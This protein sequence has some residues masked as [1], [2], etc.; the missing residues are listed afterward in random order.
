[1]IFK[2]TKLKGA[3]FID[4]ERLEDERGF[5]ARTWCRRELEAHGLNARLMQCSISFN[6]K[7]GTL[8]GMHYQAAP[9]QEAKLVRCTMGAVY[10]VI[11]DL[12]PSSITFKQWIGVELSAENRKMLYVPEGFAHG[13]QTLVEA[14]EVFYQ[15]SKIF[16]PEHTLGMRWND[17]TLK[18]AWPLVPTVLSKRDESFPYL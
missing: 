1:M 9:Y 6:K 12:R 11:I 3:F 15:I 2:E 17:P 13:F 18:I 7:R 4:P 5:F 14:S 10:D 16:H 8:R